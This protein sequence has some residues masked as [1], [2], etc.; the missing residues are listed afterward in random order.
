MNS[1][2][3]SG[4][5]IQTQLNSLFDELA[6]EEQSFFKKEGFVKDGLINPEYWNPCKGVLFILKEPAD[7]LT[8]EQLIYSAAEVH[9]ATM[10]ASPTPNTY[11]YSAGW[12]E[13]YA[14]TL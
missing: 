5:D 6:K 7:K 12:P 9:K 13:V 2:L 14:D 1:N 10:L 4:P 3:R 11:D 8:K